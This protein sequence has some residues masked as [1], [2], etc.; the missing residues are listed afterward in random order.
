MP[1]P[2][3]AFQ[4]YKFRENILIYFTQLSLSHPD[5]YSNLSGTPVLLASVLW[6]IAT[7]ATPLW[8][9]D[10]RLIESPANALE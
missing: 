6:H 10:E 9:D 4:F 8:E 5:V 1:F 7:L 3:P 2:R